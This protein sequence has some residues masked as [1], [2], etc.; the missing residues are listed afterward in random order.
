MVVCS[1]RVQKVPRSDLHRAKKYYATRVIHLGNELYLHLLHSTQVNKMGTGLGWES[2]QV[3][4]WT[5]DPLTA[6]I[7]DNLA[8]TL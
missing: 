4:Q 5:S 1:L 6:I 3:V 2:K 7:Y 8:Q